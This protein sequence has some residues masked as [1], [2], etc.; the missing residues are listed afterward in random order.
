MIM[1]PKPAIKFSKYRVSD[2]KLTAVRI[3]RTEREKI[4]KLLRLLAKQHMRRDY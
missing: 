3:L 2:I 4:N 1:L